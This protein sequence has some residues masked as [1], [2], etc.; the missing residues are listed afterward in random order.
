MLAL[1]DVR[2]AYAG[3]ETHYAFTLDAPRSVVTAIQGASGSGKSTLLDL[4]SGF[5]APESGVVRI[6]GLNVTALPPETRPVSILFQSETLFDHLSAERNVSLALPRPDQARVEAALAEVGLPGIGPQRASTLSGGQKQRVALA[7]TL[8][9]NRPV[10]L[11]DEPFSAL[12][13]DTRGATRTLVKDL[14]AKHGWATVLVTHHSDDVEAI[15]S[16]LYRLENG[17]LNLSR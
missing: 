11:L 14:T 8:L 17:V 2:F 4:I 10:L 9:R 15:A 6:D 1:E 3:T 5:L 13:D 16:R 7:R 12:D